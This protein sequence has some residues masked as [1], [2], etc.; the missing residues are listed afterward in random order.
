MIEINKK[1]HSVGTV[2]TYGRNKQKKHSVG[3]VPTYD[4]NKHKIPHCCNSSNI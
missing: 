4:R 3:T 2:P 1:Y